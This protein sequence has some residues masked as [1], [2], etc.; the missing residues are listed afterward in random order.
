MT[1]FTYG[2]KEE[3]ILE[4]TSTRFNIDAYITDASYINALNRNGEFVL[5]FQPYSTTDHQMLLER[6]ESAK[7]TVMMGMSPYSNKKPKLCIENKYGVPFT[8]QLFAPKVN[9][10]FEHADML[11]GRQASLTVHLR[12]AVDGTIY[13]QL[14]YLDLYEPI[15]SEVIEDEIDDGW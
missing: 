3:T 12:D 1:T 7:A 10:E 4:P 14:E 15:A 8:S 13:L 2:Y 11:R 5:E 6:C 9:E